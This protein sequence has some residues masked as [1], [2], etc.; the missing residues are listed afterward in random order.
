MRLAQSQLEERQDDDRDTVS[1]ASASVAAASAAISTPSPSGNIPKL[2]S[3]PLV[4]KYKSLTEVQ[5][6]ESS[7]EPTP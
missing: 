7:K 5:E 4:V 1:A 2:N 3:G 6:F